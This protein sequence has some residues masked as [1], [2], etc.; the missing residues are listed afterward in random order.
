MAAIGRSQEAPMPTNRPV[1]K[2]HLCAVPFL[3]LALLYACAPADNGGD[4]SG[5]DAGS[6]TGGGSSGFTCTTATI[7]AGNPTHD[8]PM[9]RPADGTG[10]LADPP[11]PYRTVAFSNGQLIT[12][13]GQEIWRANL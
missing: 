13:D 4:G 3:V 2:S 7:F 11:F 1:A 5:A 8:D 10:L 9:L 6:S 12:H